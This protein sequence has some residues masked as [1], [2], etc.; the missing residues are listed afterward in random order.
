M[1]GRFG[2]LG[3]PWRSTHQYL[4]G[5]IASAV[6]ASYPEKR[7]GVECGGEARGAGVLR[8][9]TVERSTLPP[10]EVT[11]LMECFTDQTKTDNFYVNRLTTFDGAEM[12]FR[13]RN[14]ITGV[15]RPTKDFDLQ[16]CPDSTAGTFCYPRSGGVPVP[17]RN[18]VLPRSAK[19]CS[20][21]ITLSSVRETGYV[22]SRRSGAITWIVRAAAPF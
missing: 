18:D 15:V 7:A 14:R 16:V 20:A 10:L 13:M 6:P 3:R 1:R 17:D 9:A 2:S 21:P 22:G 5:K 19:Y 8:P 4:P 12:P 11:L